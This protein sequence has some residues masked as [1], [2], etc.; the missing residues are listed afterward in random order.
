MEYVDLNIEAIMPDITEIL[1]RQGMPKNSVVQDKIKSLA[2]K[3]INTFSLNSS[4]L[5]IISE[6]SISKFD[7]I[8]EGEGNNEKET[9]LKNIY[10]SADHLALFA[11]TMGSKISE[12]IEY[13]FNTDDF[14]LGS[15][16]DAAASLAADR[17]TI[18]L[19]TYFND[20]IS[21]DSAESSDNIVMSYS[22]G[23][24][25]WNINAQ[26]KLFEYLK[27]GKIGIKLNESFLMTPLKSVTGVLVRGDKEIHLFESSFSFCFSCIDK[28]C[29]DRMDRIL[30]S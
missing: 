4:P 11:I 23:Y 17:S 5:S 29:Y 1:E 24:C 6:I 30:K 20:K 28:T 8:F 16:L 26:K 13:L 12:E 27:P 21:K 10:P 25:G 22:P 19:E 7:E 18:F 9:P 14:A 3:A 2:E 15:M